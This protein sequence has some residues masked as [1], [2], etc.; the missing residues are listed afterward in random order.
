M[1]SRR[2]PK[3]PSQRTPF[4][5]RENEM[6][7][8]SERLQAAGRGEG[9]VV[10]VSGEPGIGKTRLMEEVAT[11]ARG[12]DWVTLLGHAYDAAG[13]PPYLPFMEALQDY[14]RQCPLAELTE[15]LGAGAADVA[16]ILPELRQR[17]PYLPSSVQGD[18][19]SDRY[20]LFESISSF[21]AAIARSSAG[22]LLCLDDLHWADDSTLLLVEHLA[23]RASA[24]P[25]VILATYRDTDLAVALP[26][27]RALEQ[28]NKQQLSHRLELKRLNKRDVTAILAA[29]GR[30][31]PPPALV[32][33]IYRETEGNPFF[34]REVFE[35]LA[36][37][38]RL[39]DAQDA[40][41]Q[42]LRLEETDVP[43][44]VRLVIGRR[45][46]RLGDECRRVLALA[47]ILGRSFNYELLRT[48]ANLPEDSLL[49]AIE[50]A[51]QA[52][53]LTSQASGQVTF[54]HEL[55]RQTLLAG[56]S[57]MRRLQ[58]HLRAAEAI[59]SLFSNN[60][61]AHASALAEHYGQAGTA[62]SNL[63]KA[64]IYS[65]TA[66]A[67]AMAVFGHGEA[68]R[69]FEQA[70]KVQTALSP[71]A[72]AK[73]CDLLLALGDALVEAGD[74]RRVVEEV[75][76][77]AFGL[78]QELD[79]GRRASDACQAAIQASNALGP[80]LAWGSPEV[81]RW[82]VLADRFA[83]EDSLARVWSD[84]A[85]GL[86]LTRSGQR[87]EGRQFLE[88]ARKLSRQLEDLS[89][90]WLADT[91]Y[92]N[93][94]S[95]PQ[96]EPDL[97]ALSQELATRSTANASS[98]AVRQ[99]LIYRQ[100]HFLIGGK[101]AEVELASNDMRALAD[102][103]HQPNSE[104]MA[105]LLSGVALVLDG[106]LEEAMEQGDQVHARVVGEL[107][108][109]Q[110]GS[111]V[112][113]WYARPALY[114][115]RHEVLGQMTTSG[116]VFWREFVAA[117]NGSFEAA[118]ALLDAT[119]NERMSLDA[120]EDEAS[121]RDDMALLEMA[122]MSAHKEGAELLVR[123]YERWSVV[124]SG[125]GGFGPVSVARL[126]G[127]ACAML[128]RPDDARR[129]L[130]QAL[131]DMTAMRFR[132]E[133]ALVRLALA[134][135][136]LHD[137]PDQLRPANEYLDAAIP[138][139]E[140]MKMNPALKRA[141]RLR[142]RRRMAA[143][144]KSLPLTDG[145]TEREVDVLRLVAAGKSSREIAEELVLSVRTVERHIANIYLKTDT[146]GRAQ[147]TTYALRQGYT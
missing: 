48:L 118:R 64:L 122:I 60:L 92:L 11:A 10:L 144:P 102:K 61:D 127:E 75:A 31:G 8:L 147:I 91:A 3:S 69:H 24:V 51:E 14:V 110:Y 53:L 132:P 15:Q 113:E 34:V 20:R 62:S 5:G 50:E 136:L 46:D 89:A 9:G 129:H 124:T 16:L 18:P 120:A 35:H 125:S 65:E 82:A 29:L 94:V 79:D 58:M 100:R 98:M 12:L 123:R 87:R 77:A 45:L 54:V 74:P 93:G 143:V 142:G 117:A 106:R 17:L 71:A 66:A 86:N 76:P 22:L 83:P 68:V 112:A 126:L 72:L 67:Q 21:A 133:T 6:A 101:R 52:L 116:S 36:E 30:P 84:I 95:A 23:R 85:L 2:P 32:E 78:A 40:W 19:Q 145:L 25:L 111:A 57:P 33:S 141:L 1:T 138:E 107:G 13:M 121:V 96:L 115:G 70:L 97:L 134:D 128:C 88:R 43:Q 59:E 146:H 41:R 73:R 63:A 81:T 119:V 56:L 37:E 131:A 104:M 47:S 105:G 109:A 137:F 7:S 49:A 55:I 99:G 27:A 130:D 4:V 135:L 44:S 90:V 140:A 80:L 108:I 39:F 28:L 139:F 26:F 103:T 38:G 114:L 42:D